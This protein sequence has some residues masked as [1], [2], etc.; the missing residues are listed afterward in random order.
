MIPKKRLILC[1]FG[2]VGR[3]FAR[4]LSEK[5]PLLVERYGFEPRLA[6][7]VD[8]GGAAVDARGGLDGARLAA[9]A[10]A[11]DPVEA[12]PGA[13]RPGLTGIQAIGSVAA[14]VL[15][16]ATP[17]HL[18]DGEPARSHFL[19]AFAGGLD[20]VTANKAPMVLDYPGIR[21][22]ARRAGRRL[23]M[24]AAAAAALPTLDVG[25]VST[26]GARIEAIEGILNGTT[27]YIL[28]RMTRSGCPYGQAL[29][30]A[31]EM[32]IAETDPTLDVE[33]LDTRNKIL[34]IASRLTGGA[35]TP[36]A[37]ETRGITTV[38]PEDI[39][40]AAKSG[41]VIKL[42]GA[43]RSVDGGYRLTVGPEALEPGHPL[44]AVDGS[45][46][47]ISYLTD[48]MGRITV[49]GGRSSPVGAAAALLKDLVHAA[50]AVDL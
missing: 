17:T 34:L 14:E 27:N 9:F 10:E 43:C 49:T 50:G 7:V 8:I 40:T 31:Q 21:E 35:F 28:T 11:G 24:S 42:V 4:L 15:V 2:N 23:F 37:V 46:K 13:G 20:V 38:T 39:R 48:T 5:R 25:L 22:A 26:A 47:G 1:G 18:T 41:R 36:E 45:E 33:G 3:A 30:E 19:A 29:A 6:A 12:F 16:E 32:G 44:A